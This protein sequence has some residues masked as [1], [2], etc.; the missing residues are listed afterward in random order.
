MKYFESYDIYNK[1]KDNK[2]YDYFFDTPE[3]HYKVSISEYMESYYSIG[4]KARKIDSDDFFNF[5][6]ITN[7]N[8][9][10][11]M[12]TVM[13]SIEEFYLEKI[14][15]IENYNKQFKLNLNIN[16]FFKGFV[17][18]FNNDNKKNIQRLNLYKK[19]IDKIE[20]FKTDL[21]KENNFYF[22]DIKKEL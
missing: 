4:F 5:N 7:Q 21:R 10:K 17:F 20:L 8:T 11:V 22:L 6:I 19:Y 1:R 15:E 12:E 18:S 2:N 16:D 14:Q 9:Y 13:K 3:Y